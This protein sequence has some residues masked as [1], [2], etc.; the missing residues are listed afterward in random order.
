MR[1]NNKWMIPA[2]CSGVALLVSLAAGL[3]LLMRRRRPK[4]EPAGQT[5]EN[6][7][8]AAGVAGKEEYRDE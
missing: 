1:Q 8:E 3:L 6:G 2:V 5:R 7:S 4:K